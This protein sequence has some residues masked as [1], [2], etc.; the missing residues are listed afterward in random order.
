MPCESLC[1]TASQP[2]LTQLREEQEDH[3]EGGDDGDDAARRRAVEKLGR[4]FSLHLQ[5]SREGQISKLFG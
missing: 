1:I 5:D 2:A 3:E 4:L